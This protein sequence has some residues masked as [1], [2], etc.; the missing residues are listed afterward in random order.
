MDTLAKKLEIIKLLLETDNPEIL[1]SIKELLTKDPEA[2]FLDR[3][4]NQEN[5]IFMDGTDDYDEFIK[6]YGR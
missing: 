4:H 1:E 3:M 5:N 2:N 6:K